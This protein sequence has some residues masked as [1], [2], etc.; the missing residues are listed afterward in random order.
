MSKI[1]FD[2]KIIILNSRI[3]ILE[4]KMITFESRMIIY[5]LRINILECIRI[6]IISYKSIE[7]NRAHKITTIP[8]QN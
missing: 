1:I 7:V 3:I 6:Y 2:L 8:K 5:D 4:L